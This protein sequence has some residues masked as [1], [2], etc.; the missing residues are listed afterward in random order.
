[1][2]SNAQ[3]ALETFSYDDKITRQFVIATL[4]WGAVGML[5]GLVVALEL[6]FWQVNGGI[7]WITFGRLR[8]LH[9]NAIIFAFAA[10][11]IFAAVYYS[12]QRLLK[13]RMASDLLSRIHFW[14]WQL[15]I[16]SAAITLPLGLTSSKE[17]AELEWPIDIMIA[18]VWVVFGV[19][20]FWTIIKRREQH[21]YV[22]LWFYIATIVTIAMLH[23]VNSLAIPVSLFKSYSVFAGVQ[24][25][26]TQWWYGHNA[27]GF[28]LT[29]P[30][31]GMMYYYLPKAAERPI[32][33]Y[34][35][36]VV[37]F[38]ALVF[39]YIWAGPH[40]LHYTALPDWA[41]T[42]GMV[43]SLILL[44]PSWGGML[45]GLLTLRGV[46]NK[47]REE[48]ILKFFVVAITF[49]GM[50]TFEGPMMSIKSVNSLT[51]YTDYTVAHVHS[52][53][54]GWVGFMIFGTFYYMVP[55]LWR[56]PL[57]S[58]S[59]ANLHFWIATIGIILYIVP[60]WIAG[61]M[62]G[63]M[64]RAF[65]AE[66][67][68]LYP[69]FV[70]TTQKILPFYHTRVL[71]GLLYLSGFL[72]MIYNLRKTCKGAGNLADETAQAPSLAALQ[73]AELSPRTPWHHLLTGQPLAFTLL[74]LVVA[75]VGGI[76]EI[77]PLLMPK[78]Y[79][80]MYASAQTPYTPL[81]LEGRDLFIREGC[82]Q[83]H[84]Q[85]I[86]P[87]RDEVLRYGDYSKPGESEFD[88]PFLW[89]SRRIGPDLAR[90]GGKYPDHWHYLHFQ[91]PRATSPGSIMPAFP[92][93]LKNTLNTSDIQP[94]LNAMR[95]LN[96]PYTEEDV[97]NAPQEL[98]KQA[99]QIAE[100]LDKEGYTGAA[101]K[102]VVAV[103]A[104][105]QRLGKLPPP[106]NLARL[107]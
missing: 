102:E 7:P 93:L 95:K 94:K 71:G 15:I 41:Q 75:T 31:L 104:Y 44:A 35:L 98:E 55:R 81:E 87:M 25:A 11:A 43:F 76:V 23:I 33:S 13:T 16:V 90:E 26:M 105:L 40:H 49:Y 45:N 99:A 103:I 22:A 74:A 9:T 97:K 21:L 24:D 91:N 68:L 27:V 89:G 84:S 6:A 10:N 29:T 82:V 86:R 85:M 106:S 58:K 70:E 63:L 101:D 32:Y 72:L 5:V 59:K 88:H 80:P 28:L 100:R 57:Y 77:G 92:W 30:F 1:M 53:A 3:T 50:S 36:S 20:F 19:N 17:Y 52:G 62:Q 65:D 39:V 67:M 56:K 34:R 60:I 79:V 37:H 51:H 64:W 47:V 73:P 38:W 54:L 14:G 48:P 4:L 2:T 96:V 107:P 78:S 46:W 12:S 18:L 8:P 66:G 61:L 83:C 42:L 69:N